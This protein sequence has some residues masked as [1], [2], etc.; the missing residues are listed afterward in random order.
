M[1]SPYAWN[2]VVTSRNVGAGGDLG[3]EVLGGEPD[4]EARRVRRMTWA[5]PRRCEEQRENGI[6][7]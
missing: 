1:I 6:H 4:Q 7:G 2:I 5:S 3:L